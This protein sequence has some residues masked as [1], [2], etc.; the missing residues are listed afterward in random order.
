MTTLNSTNS[1]FLTG[2]SYVQH[3]TVNLTRIARTVIPRPKSTMSQ[4]P[5][6]NHLM[7]FSFCKFTAECCLLTPVNW[8][9]M[10]PVFWPR[11]PDTMMLPMPETRLMMPSTALLERDGERAM[12]RSVWDPCDE[13]S[14]LSI[15]LRCDPIVPELVTPADNLFIQGMFLSGRSTEDADAESWLGVLLCQRN[16]VEWLSPAGCSLPEIGVVFAVDSVC[17]AFTVPSCD[18]CARGI[19]PTFC[20]RDLAILK[21]WAVMNESATRP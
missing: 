12:S 3:E 15:D 18:V 14:D 16:G 9:L 17:A 7:R 4:Y 2:L 20:F 5:T 11:T 13:V 19:A 8:V 10:G 21:Y 1:C 6:M